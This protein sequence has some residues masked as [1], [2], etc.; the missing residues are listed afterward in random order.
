MNELLWVAAKRTFTIPGPWPLVR[1]VSG[2]VNELLGW[3][4][5]NVHR[6]WPLAPLFSQL[7]FFLLALLSITASTDGHDGDLLRCFVCKRQEAA[8]AQE[9]R[10]FQAARAC[11]WIAAAPL[12]QNGRVTTRPFGEDLHEIFAEIAISTFSNLRFWKF[13][14]DF[15]EICMHSLS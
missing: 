5:K 15:A 3:R 11:M 9:C 1:L 14:Q 10:V 2:V 12:N 4:P 6:P 7:A 8:S 13:T